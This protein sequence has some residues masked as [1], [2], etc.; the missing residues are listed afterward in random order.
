MAKVWL[1]REGPDPTRGEPTANIPV[2]QAQGLLGLRHDHFYRSFDEERPR[3]GDQSKK[4]VGF[5]GERYVVVEIDDA[6]GVAA[7]WKPGFYLI[8]ELDPKEA[9][10]RLSAAK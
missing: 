4:A 3:F 2:T 1:V 10:K 5:G 8:V 6:E 7:G 9:R